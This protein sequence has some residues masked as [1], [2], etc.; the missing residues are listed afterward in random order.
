M[1]VFICTRHHTHTVHPLR[2]NRYMP[3]W[4]AITYD[5]LFRSFSV[6]GAVYVFTDLD[7]LGFWE[8][9]LAARYFRV[10]KRAGIPVLNDPASFKPRFDLL[11]ELHATGI[12]H[13]RVWRA[14]ERHL[15]D[16]FPVF[17]RTE[18][19]HRGPLTDLL[20]TKQELDDAVAEARA[21]GYPDIDLMIVEYMAAPVREGLFRKLS[22]YRIG[23]AMVTW[24]AVHEAHWTAKGG[25]L[26]I[27]GADLYEEEYASVRDNIYGDTL[28]PAFD[29][30]ATEYGR[31]DFTFVDGRLEVYEINTNPGVGFGGEHPF[32]VRIESNR[33]SHE[34]YGKAF[35]ALIP[36]S[37]PRKVA[38]VD[39]VLNRQ[40]R[41]EW[42]GLTR[43]RRTP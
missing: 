38:I 41:R 29:I 13:F 17:L 26:G 31:A 23:D 36:Q 19:G 7:R 2:K 11:S 8:L 5:K 20:H 18:R 33:L 3:P 14:R 28:R 39:E 1:I 4:R 42:L 43:S 30:A 12:N 9:E 34:N 21:T 35:A 27:A 32:A 16:R 25:S 22:V 6:P 40:A 10:L 37:L 24:L 15:V